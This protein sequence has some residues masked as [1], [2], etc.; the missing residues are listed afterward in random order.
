MSMTNSKHTRIALVASL[1]VM[2]AP[3]AAQ[4]QRK[5]PLE[6]APAIRKRVELRET[7]FE[8]GT[9]LSSTLTQDFYNTFLVDLRLAFHFND[10]LALA[11]TGG[12]AVANANTGFHDRIVETLNTPAPLPRDPDPSVAQGSMQKIKAL[13][14]AQLEF[15]PFTGKYSLFGKLFAHYDFYLFGGGGFMDV[16]PTNAAAC[17]GQPMA[18]CGV[19]GFKPGGQG[20]V[21][22]HTFFNHWLALNVE[23]KDFVARLN[24]SGRDNNGDGVADSKDT[25]WT[26]TFMVGANIMFFLPYQ[27]AISQ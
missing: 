25:R 18:Y 2:L 16:E 11:A 10:W 9:G 20:G 3:L 21:G 19:T 8:I 22:L 5:S 4:A 6:D 27:A 13:A 1:L 23:L 7:R 15:T 24:P 17:V 14:G 26:Q 12:F